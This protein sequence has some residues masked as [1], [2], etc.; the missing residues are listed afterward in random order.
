[1]VVVNLGVEPYSTAFVVCDF[2]ETSNTLRS[3]LVYAPSSPLMS[4]LFSV[5]VSDPYRRTGST[6]VLMIL[7]LI[8]R[9]ILDFQNTSRV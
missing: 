9:D 5:Q 2:H 8:H 4:D 3:I 1:M 7:I 6:A